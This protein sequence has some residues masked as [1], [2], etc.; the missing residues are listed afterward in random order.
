MGTGTPEN[1]RVKRPHIL[2]LTAALA[3]ALVVLLASSVCLAGVRWTA[4]GVKI[5]TAVNTQENVQI[6]SD[7]SGGAIITWMDDRLSIHSD[8]YA[9]RVDS[10][11]GI[12]S[13]W[14]PGG[15]LIC[16]APDS[17]ADPQIT[18]DGSGG[19]IITWKDNRTGFDFDIYAQRVDSGGNIK[20]TATGVPICTIFGN[21]QLDP[22]ITSDG[23]GGAVITWTDNRNSGTTDWDIY[24]QRIDFDSG[25]HSGWAVNGELICNALNNQLDPRIT[26]DGSGG[27]VITWTDRRS[28]T[29]Y[30][31]YAQRIDSGGNVK[32]T[33]N[34]VAICTAANDQMDPGI[35][36]EGSGGAI[37]TWNDGREGIGN[38]NIYAQRVG[39]GGNVKWV[40]NGVAIC[41]AAGNQ[42][43][44]RITSDGT[45]G[46]VVSWVD[47]RSGA[48]AD[49]Y[50]Q[51]VGLDGNVEWTGN[52]VA[53]CTAGGLQKHAEITSDGS[54]GA[55]ITWTDYRSGLNGDIYAQR[56]GQS[57]SRKWTANGVVVCT[58]ADDQAFPRITSDGTG[59]GIVAWED[60]R[61]GPANSN[62]YAQRISNP[63]PTVTSITP[64]GGANDR[65][66][67]ITNLKGTNFRGGA[68]VKLTGPSGSGETGAGT[69]TATDVSVA[70][71][72][73]IT[74]EFNLSG[75][76]AG[77]YQVKVE[78]TDGQSAGKANAFEVNFPNSAW[79]LAEGTTA[80]GFDCY[81]TIENP[82]GSEVTA[83]VTYMTGTGA[84]PGGTFN[85]PAASQTAINPRDTLG[86]QDFSTHVVC[87]E[88]R[89]IAVDR[90]MYWT[91]PGA[92]SPDGHCSIGVTSPAK[93]WYLAEGSSAWGFECWL[94]LQNPNQNEATCT[95]TY[96]IEGADPVTVEKKIPG[97][98][99]ESY[100]M[101]DDIGAH[102]ASIKV[103]GDIPVIPERAMYRNNRR[104][105]HDSIGTTAPASNFYLAEGTTAWGFTTYILVQNPQ[106]TPTD[107]TVTYM[108]N[109]GPVTQQPF[110]MPENSRKTIRVNDVLPD[111]DLSTQVHGSQEII[112]ERAM[113][114]GE[115]TAL[116]EACHDSIGLSA[117]HTN[118]YL[119]DGQT[120]EGR[121]TYTLVQNPND[122]DVTVEVTYLTPDGAGNV[123]F[124]ETIAANSRSTFSMA[125]KGIDGRAAIVVTCK[126]AGKKIMVE[127][128]MY[129]NSRGAG[130]DTIGGYSD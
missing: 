43:V 6:T 55:I 56:V 17:Q 44:P 51:K 90:T 38:N 75:A 49:I 34:G 102:D 62:I 129:W 82:N 35:I 73:K 83:D 24:A 8:I 65:S 16:N 11:G 81:V 27:A 19:A 71:S 42:N 21:D 101:A 125:D 96:M 99:R 127:R 111:T 112:A 97:N 92:P 69:I 67:T 94:L 107:V 3:A 123:V 1:A 12:H 22:R 64:E 37:I 58:A 106:D 26:S 7:G 70:S 40:G 126:T 29:N 116:G 93:T 39:S 124:E 50:A 80:W 23:S 119:P 2:V 77:S 41:T 78:N 76:Q 95:V 4:N 68:T 117:P 103:V 57:G 104:E 121:E 74:C 52:G 130:T 13:G 45:G 122:T 15:E 47:Y 84:V 59:G 86:D 118:F 48:N 9:Q 66:V 88:G 114:W 20:W 120:S 89:T 85:L 18:S 105:G 109:S 53:V 61:S 60:L 110:N 46:A 98:T 30:D 108:T 100:N 33:A 113:Y 31:I 36:S 63:A 91:G 115:G 5:C 72:T 54:G 10:D 14:A 32:W 28:G 25:I 87:N 79:Y 128:A